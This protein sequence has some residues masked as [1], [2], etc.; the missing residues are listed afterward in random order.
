MSKQPELRCVRH[1]QGE[2]H[3]VMGDPMRFI[4][5]AADTG[6]DYAISEVFSRPGNGA[7]PHIHHREDEAFYVLEG[8]Y[9]V[10]VDGQTY[11]LNKG[12]FAHVPRGAVRAFINVSDQAGR[13]L[14][15]HCPGAAADFYINMGKLP[16]PPQLDQIAAIGEQYGIEIVT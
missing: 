9:D 12:D 10:N 11:R 2:S 15:L 7:P 4:M 16:Q 1:D 13:L 8:E 6:G 14:I 3:P 5:T